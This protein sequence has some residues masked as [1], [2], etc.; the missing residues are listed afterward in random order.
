MGG[1]HHVRSRELRLLQHLLQREI[2][3][4]KEK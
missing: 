3:K 1:R 2:N 4:V